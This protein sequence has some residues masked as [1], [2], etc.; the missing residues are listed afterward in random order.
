YRFFA[1]AGGISAALGVTF[2]IGLL[3]F[4]GRRGLG[5]D[6]RRTQFAELVIFRHVPKP[7]SSC[8]GCSWDSSWPRRAFPATGPH[9]DGS[10]R[11][12]RADWTS[13]GGRA[14]RAAPCVRP[15]C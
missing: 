10:G 6:Q 2:V 11:D 12:R 7:P 3:R 14:D 8:T 1:A 4:F 9:A 5:L 13:G 15:P